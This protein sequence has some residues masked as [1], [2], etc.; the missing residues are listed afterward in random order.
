MFSGFF[1]LKRVL[2]SFLRLLM[3]SINNTAIATMYMMVTITKAVL[4]AGESGSSDP[5]TAEGK[6]C[7]ASR[8]FVFIFYIIIVYGQKEVNKKFHFFQKMLAS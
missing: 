1:S 4:N 3:K 5:G 8:P 2:G 7:K 6:S